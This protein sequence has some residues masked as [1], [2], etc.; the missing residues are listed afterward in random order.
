MSSQIYEIIKTIYTTTPD[1]ELNPISADSEDSSPRI[2]VLQSTLG[3]LRLNN[4]ATLDAITTHFTRLIDL[5]SA[6]EEY[7]VKLANV[8]APCI[9]RPKS[10]NPL[11]F[12][13]KYAYRLIRDLFDHKEAIFGELKRQ[14]SMLGTLGGPAG[15][16][17]PNRA[18]A[19]SNTDESNRRAN[20]EARAKAINEQR[21]REKSPAPVNR[22]KRELST[23]RFPVVASPR[24]ES[25]SFTRNISGAANRETLEVPGSLESSPISN[26]ASNPRLNAMTTASPEVATATSG[27]NGQPALEATSSVPESF[28]GGGPGPHIPPPVDDDNQVNESTDAQIEHTSSTTS[29]SLRRNPV[30]SGGKKPA[31]TSGNL[32]GALKRNTSRDMSVLSQQNAQLPTRSEGVTLEDKPM[33]DFS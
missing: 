33:D 12:E 15:P 24:P 2:K 8:F 32:G 19:I 14:S 27:M 17:N 30:G 7:I 4:I 16:S 29:Q 18:R 31:R 3:Q 21:S 25:G 1:A 9:L 26:R 5:T 22:H 23:G 11:I 10:G 6:D 20:M 28:A 13:E